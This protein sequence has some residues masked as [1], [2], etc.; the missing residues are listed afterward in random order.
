MSSVLPLLGYPEEVRS[1]VRAVLGQCLVVGWLGVML[2]KQELLALLGADGDGELGTLS[3]GVSRFYRVIA[4]GPVVV[5]VIYAVGYVNLARFLVRGGM[6]T[7]LVLLF[8]P[9]A[10]QKLRELSEQVLGFPA[11]RSLGTKASAH[12]PP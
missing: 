6:V 12:T 11:C 2:R 8:A 7:L 10:H 9:W 4:L 5:Y 3:A 1:L